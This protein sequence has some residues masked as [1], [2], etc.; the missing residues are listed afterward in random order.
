MVAGLKASFGPGP[1]LVVLL[2]GAAYADPV[3]AQAPDDW[4]FEEP[5]KGLQ[6]GERLRWFKEWRA[7]CTG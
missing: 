3:R 7:A 6:V 4:T 1:L 5:L 2:G